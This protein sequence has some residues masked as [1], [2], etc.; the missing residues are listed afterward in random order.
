MEIVGQH[1]ARVH[2]P[3]GR[4]LVCSTRWAGQHTS[5]RSWTSRWVTCASDSRTATSNC[6]LD[7]AAAQPAREAGFDP[8][9]GARPAEARDSAAAG[10]SAGA[11]DPARRLR[12][13]R[14]D[15]GHRPRRRA[16]LREAGRRADRG[17]APPRLT[18][19]GSRRDRIIA[20]LTHSRLTKAMPIY[21]YECQKCGP[22]ARGP[23]EV[24][25]QAAA[26][27]PRMR[28]APAEAA[29]CQAPLFAGRQRLVRNRLQVGQGAQAQH[30]R[31]G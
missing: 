11:V 12:A 8:V 22:H 13:G 10:E 18:R 28:Q 6:E 2:Q 3:R 16:R 20:A 1:S 24:L 17:E 4:A 25:R 21:E 9:Y 31:E 14:P 23:A 26:R 19:V 27:V 29:R 30:P 7:D 5:A 15:P